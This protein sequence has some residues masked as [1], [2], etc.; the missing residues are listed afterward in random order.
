MMI[1]IQPMVLML[2]QWVAHGDAL[3]GTRPCA[4]GHNK[5]RV[6]QETQLIPVRVRRR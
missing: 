2:G 3:F 4:A 5:G 6:G 1:K